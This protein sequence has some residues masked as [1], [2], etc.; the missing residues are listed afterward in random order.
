MATERYSGSVCGVALELALTF[1]M[2]LLPTFYRFTLDAWRPIETT[3]TDAGENETERREPPLRTTSGTVFDAR[4]HTWELPKKSGGKRKI[5]APER[6]LKYLQRRMLEGGFNRLLTEEHLGDSAHG[7]IPGRNIVTNA[8]PHIGQPL[9]V[10]VDIES[11][12]PSIRYALILKAVAQLNDLEGISLSAAAQRLIADLCSYQGALPTGSPT[13]P[14][15]ANLTL[16]NLDQSL[17]TLCMAQ[18]IT[19]TRY[20][21]DLTF[22]GDNSARTVLPFVKKCLAELGLELDEKKTNLF[23][24]GRRQIVTGLVVNEKPNLPRRL[25]RELRAAVHRRSHG[26]TPTWDDRPMDDNELAGRLAFLQ[27]VQPEEAERHRQR[28]RGGE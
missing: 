14:A 26:V 10:N 5:T 21:D 11:F 18:G 8:A 1:G 12:F 16:R 27:M 20:A 28:L 4:Y 19:Y 7:F 17:A 23:R 13:S 6:S 24:R 15:I 3:A 25:R 2:D 9:V 22:S